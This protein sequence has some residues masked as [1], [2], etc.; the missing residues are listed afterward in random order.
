MPCLLKTLLVWEQKEGIMMSKY[1]LRGSQIGA[2]GDNAKSHNNSFTMNTLSN[3][4]DEIIKELDLICQNIIRMDN[5]N[6]EEKALLKH[7]QDLKK[8]KDKD[9]LVISIKTKATELFYN[10]SAGVGSG[11]VA[12]I[13]SKVING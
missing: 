10:F 7:I 13:I 11:I 8:I 3:E 1:D 6:E 9:K 2:V 4:I 12:N 5:K